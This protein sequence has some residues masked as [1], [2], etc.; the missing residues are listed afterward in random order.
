MLHAIINFFNDPFFFDLYEAEHSPDS[1][2]MTMLFDQY[3]RLWS[4]RK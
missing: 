3:D 1:K 4:N 2:S